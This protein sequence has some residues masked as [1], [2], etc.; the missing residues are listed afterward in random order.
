MLKLCL[1]VFDVLRDVFMDMT[2]SCYGFWSWTPVS[3]ARKFILDWRAL[4]TFL[5]TGSGDYYYSNSSSSVLSRWGEDSGAVSGWLVDSS[6][7]I[8]FILLLLLPGYFSKPTIY[9]P[10]YFACLIYRSLKYLLPFSFKPL[11][12]LYYK[13]G[14]SFSILSKTY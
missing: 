11:S 8:Q 10:L 7:K 2:S 12:I 9:K 14:K 6:S 1:W 4:A 3:L 13:G 5:I